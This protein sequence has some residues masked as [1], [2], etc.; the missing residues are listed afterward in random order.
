MVVGILWFWGYY[1]FGDN[2][3]LEYYGFGDI[4]VLGILWL[5]RV[6][7]CPYTAENYVTSSTTKQSSDN[8]IQRTGRK[9]GEN[10][11]P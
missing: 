2:R 6:F 1:G 3:V 8:M 9:G 11:T 10:A 4:M 5:Y 7:P